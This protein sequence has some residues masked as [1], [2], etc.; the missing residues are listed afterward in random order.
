MLLN[1]ANLGDL[2]S[3]TTL[4]ISFFSSGL[5][6]NILSPTLWQAPLFTR[7]L[8]L[9]RNP[10]LPISGLLPV[11]PLTA[12]LLLPIGSSCLICP[13]ISCWY[14]T[15]PAVESLQ[16]ECFGNATEDSRTSGLQ[17]R[18]KQCMTAG[19]CDLPRISLVPMSRIPDQTCT[20]Q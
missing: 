20:S 9:E 11:L 16:K 7:W 12:R 2:G 8:L 19:L 18:T 15:N 1:P 10:C 4:A 3:V 5:C 14:C 6:C 13:Y 17:L